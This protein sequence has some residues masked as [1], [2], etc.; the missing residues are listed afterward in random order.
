MS[1]CVFSVKDLLPLIEHARAAKE[2]RGVPGRKPI[3]A[4]LLVHDDDLY[5]VSSGV[6]T[7]QEMR[8]RTYVVYARD[9]DPRKDLGARATA[10]SRVGEGAFVKQIPLR[11]V[12]ENCADCNT[13]AVTFGAEPESFTVEARRA[14]GRRTGAR[15]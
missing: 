2:H 10:R 3:P 1:T 14:P 9:C 5:L 7:E 13:L 4:L 12:L 8:D 6:Q 15:G 11:G